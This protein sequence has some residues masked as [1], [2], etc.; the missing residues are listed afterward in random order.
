VREF[1]QRHHS[2]Q[3]YLYWLDGFPELWE[4]AEDTF[5]R[6]RA[7]PRK[8]L[9][10]TLGRARWDRLLPAGDCGL[11]SEVCVGEVLKVTDRNGFLAQSKS[12][13]KE[14]EDI[15]KTEA[16]LLLDLNPVL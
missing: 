13:S 1:G 10:W 4:P 2:K 8:H 12:R 9:F 5:Q 14:Q 15:G 11:G 16:L 7:S 3:R 6:Q